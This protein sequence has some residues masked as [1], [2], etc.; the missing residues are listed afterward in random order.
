MKKINIYVDEILFG[1]IETQDSSV[2]SA[3]AGILALHPEWTNYRFEEIDITL[4]HDLALCLQRRRAEY[5]TAEQF[6]DAYFDGGEAGIEQL[7]K[8]RLAVKA[9]YPK[10][11]K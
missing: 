4:D 7:R 2:E 10:P 8:L 5:P 1:N 3:K 9:K 11:I 6:L